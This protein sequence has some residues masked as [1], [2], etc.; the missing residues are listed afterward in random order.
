MDSAHQVVRETLNPL[1]PQNFS[2]LARKI[3]MPRVG[4]SAASVGA[5][6]ELI[7]CADLMGKGF[8]VYRAL[9]PN[10]PCDLMAITPKGEC[11]RIEVK[12]AEMT[13]GGTVCA[14]PNLNRN[15]HDIL[16]VVTRTTDII[17]EP[18]LTGRYAPDA[19]VRKLKMAVQL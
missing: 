5:I 16:A 4:I 3:P 11:A 18:P 10:S 8:S 2:D 17:Y 15:Q 19:G 1:S 7:V 13:K 12:T 9:S 14:I 6:S